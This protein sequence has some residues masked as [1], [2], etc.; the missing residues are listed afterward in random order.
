ML[1]GKYQFICRFE[2]EARLPPFKGSTVRGLLGHALRRVVCALKHQQCADCLL[3]RDCLYARMF[4]LPPPTEKAAANASAE[5]HPFVLEPPLEE[6][7]VYHPGET[8]TIGLILFG[9]INRK[10]PYFIYAF[11]EMGKIGMGKR[12]GGCRGRF[13]LEQVHYGEKMVVYDP[14]E[15]NIRLPESLQELT[16]EKRPAE[17]TANVLDVELLTPL[18]FKSNGHLEDELPFDQLVRLSLRRVSSLL[19]AF[20]DGEPSLDYRGLIDRAEAVRTGSKNLAWRDFERYSGRQKRRIPLGGLCG[21]VSY[22]GDIWEFLP[23]I[24]FATQTNIGKN[25]TFGLGC[26]QAS[27]IMLQSR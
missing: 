17:A 5:P 16:L 6:K 7:T 22:E 23:L 19:G 10:L 26:F 11:D 24:E 8:I 14:S 4:G 25:T 15:G 2:D 13:K 12:V 3:R 27:W 1:Y 9:E 20:G 21:K 18:R